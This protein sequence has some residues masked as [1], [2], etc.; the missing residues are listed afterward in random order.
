MD[1]YAYMLRMMCVIGGIVAILVVYSALVVGARAD[2]WL[3]ELR[4]AA[5]DKGTYPRKDGDA[6]GQ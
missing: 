5:N 2:E 3:D 4:A 1:G 6:D